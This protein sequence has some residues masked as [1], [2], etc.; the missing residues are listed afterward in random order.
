[1]KIIHTSDIYLG[2]K[3]T[4]FKLAGDKLR[5][6]LKNT[7]SKIIDLA[8]TEKPDLLIIA[9]NLFHSL[10]ISNS[11]QNFVASE[12]AR[13]ESTQAVIM[14]GIND[15]LTDGSFWKTWQSIRENK[16]THLLIDPQKP[17]IV[18]EDLSCAIFC[19]V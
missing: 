7:F 18:L 15:K 8:N 6:G 1:M 9:G 13:L 11:L 17:F 2:K 3:F 16:N 14:P 12:L 10:D 19:K 5:A 4:G